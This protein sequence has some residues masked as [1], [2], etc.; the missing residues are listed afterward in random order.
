M[1]VPR[2]NYAFMLCT[3]SVEHVANWLTTVKIEQGGNRE[4]R[5]RLNF[6]RTD[7]HENNFGLRTWK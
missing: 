3:D 4:T 5:S 1:S 6:E 2:P 7:V